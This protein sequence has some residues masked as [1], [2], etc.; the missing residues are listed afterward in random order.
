MDM[1]LSGLEEDW[2]KEVVKLAMELVCVKRWVMQRAAG[3]EVT[4]NTNQLLADLAGR[5]S[6]GGGDLIFVNRK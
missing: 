4:I 1:D 6:D 3:A 2:E 5:A